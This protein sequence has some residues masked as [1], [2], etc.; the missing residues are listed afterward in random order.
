MQ[1]DSTPVD[2]S[3]VQTSLPPAAPDTFKPLKLP[4]S[5][6]RSSGGGGYP[7]APAAL[8]EAVSR[9][10]AF[11]RFCFQEFGQKNDP[12]LRGSV[13]MIVSVDANGVSDARVGGANWS[14]NMGSGVSRCLNEKAKKA[15]KL[16]PGAVKPGT[17]AVPLRFSGS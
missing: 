4:T 15:W 17:Y 3:K 10:Q 14:S 1:I 12:S 6:G 13:S 5:T 2:L 7:M 8:M 9:E 11:S 16:A